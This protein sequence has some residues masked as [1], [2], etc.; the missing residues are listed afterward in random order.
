MS[1]L[2]SKKASP[3]RKRIKKVSPRKS[4][5]GLDEKNKLKAAKTEPK[6]NQNYEEIDSN[7]RL[8][9][10]NVADPDYS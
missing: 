9:P 6:I 10:W 8:D 1:R 2:A 7:M 4:L 5:S 3:E